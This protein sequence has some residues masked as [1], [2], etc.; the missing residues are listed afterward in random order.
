MNED[1]HMKLHTY[2]A[3]AEVV[4]NKPFT[5]CTSEEKEIVKQMCNE[6]D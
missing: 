2:D 4:F 3:V 1:Q 5:T 6:A